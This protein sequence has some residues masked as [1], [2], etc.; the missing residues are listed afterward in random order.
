MPASS[1]A[2]DPAA[3]GGG[4]AIGGSAATAAPTSL[5]ALIRQVAAQTGVSASLIS[6]VVQ[7]ESAGNPHAVS[8]AGAKGLMQL[9]DAT[10]AEYGVT[11]P[12]DPQQNVTAGAKYLAHLLSEFNGNQQL[13]V[14][15]YNAGPGAVQQYGG[16]PPYPETQA[17]VQKVTALQQQ[18]AAGDGA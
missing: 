5:P 6:A 18:Y 9:M 12:F 3:I 7:A 14:A 17:Y 15:A 8:S 2:G 10:A 1:V 11:D 4:A 13:A 16:I